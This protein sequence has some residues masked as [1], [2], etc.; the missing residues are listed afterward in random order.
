MSKVL[1]STASLETLLDLLAKHGEITIYTAFPICRVLS[2]SKPDKK[3]NLMLT[4]DCG[5]ISTNVKQTGHFIKVPDEMVLP[6][7]SV[8]HPSYVER[9]KRFDEGQGLTWNA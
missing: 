6:L 8:A 1:F 3:G 7:S 2:A 4:T 5:T 9:L